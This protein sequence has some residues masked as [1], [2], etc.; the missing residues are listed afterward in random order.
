M[1]HQYELRDVLV[2]STK[3][4]GIDLTNEQV[5]Q[6]V[7]YLAEL[8]H[9][10]KITNLTGITDPLE[11]T[12]KHFVDSLTALTALDFPTRAVVLDVGAGAGFPGIPLKIARKDLELI[13]IEPAKKKCSFLSSI[14]G[15]LKLRDV[16]VFVGNIRQ[17]VAQT[18]YRL[19]DIIVTRGLGLNEIQEQVEAALNKEGKL[20]LYRTGRMSKELPVPGLKVLS[21]TNFTLPLNYGNRVVSVM[22]KSGPE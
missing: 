4:F 8:V 20:V 3:N 19:G 14:I 1:E 6:F 11:V 10:N 12:G 2:R 17:Y 22:V 5:E 18:E 21:E 7:L 16:S 13:L 9:W 15:R